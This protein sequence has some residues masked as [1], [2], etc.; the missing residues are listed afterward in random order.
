MNLGEVL[1]TVFPVF[2]LIG[3]GY[4]FGRFRRIDLGSL[5]D[6]VV[7]LAGPALIFSSLSSGDMPASSLAVLAAGTAAIVVGSGL[8]MKLGFSVAGRRAGALYLPA[9]FPNC[10]N[11]L[12]PLSL[13]AFG[14]D[15]L[16]YGVV[17]FA[18][19]LV[20]QSSVGVA[21]ASGRPRPMEIFRLPYIYAVVGALALSW[22]NVEVPAVVARPVALAGDMAIPTMLISLGLRLRTVAIDSWRRPLAAALVRIGGGYAVA[23]IFVALAGPEPMAA[24]CLLLASV[25]PSAVVNFIFA[26]KYAGESTDVAAAVVLSTLA[27]IVTTPLLLAFGL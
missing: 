3:V 21:L 24:S 17:I 1:N 6:L 4:L 8:L 2:A 19:N 20:L 15:G 9:M 25:M 18:T 16:R 12:L 7:Y 23:K 11:M 5:A 14:G 13:L 10:G 27:S 26:E 22:G